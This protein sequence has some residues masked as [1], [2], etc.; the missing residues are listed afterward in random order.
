MVLFLAYHMGCATVQNGS[1]WFLVRG[2][3]QMS[4]TS[5]DGILSP[6]IETKKAC[7]L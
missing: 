1:S 2:L 6:I 7:D 4:A 3:Q 5:T